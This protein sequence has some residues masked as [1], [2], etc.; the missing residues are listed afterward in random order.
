MSVVAFH[1]TNDRC[2]VSGCLGGKLRL[3][4][5]A[6][7]KVMRLNDMGDGETKRNNFITAVCFCQAGKTLCVGTYTGVCILY[8]TELLKYLSSINVRSTRGKNSKG[9]KITGIEVL[10]RDENKVRLGSAQA[11]YTVVEWRFFCSI[12]SGHVERLAYSSV[13]SA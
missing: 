1:P 8:Q 6:D 2:F 4:S 12:D 11:R 5:I 13:R 9:S 7:K 3:W 10:N